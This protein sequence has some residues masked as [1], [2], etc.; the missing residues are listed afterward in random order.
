MG[1]YA[2]TSAGLVGE[3]ELARSAAH[4]PCAGARNRGPTAAIGGPGTTYGVPRADRSALAVL[5]VAAYC[6]RG[7]LQRA[8]AAVCR[9]L[10]RRCYDPVTARAVEAAFYL[11]VGGPPGPLDAFAACCAVL[12]IVWTGAQRCLDRAVR[13]PGCPTSPRHLRRQRGVRSRRQERR[14]L[15]PPTL[16]RPT[17]RRHRQ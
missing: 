15:Q 6:S 4:G 12:D 3:S 17:I 8:R 9:W 16:R 11:G 1:D 14:P 10:L 2:A 7:V 5:L 13:S